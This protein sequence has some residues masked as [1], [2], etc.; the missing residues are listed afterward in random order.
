[1]IGTY[2]AVVTPHGNHFIE[3]VMYFLTEGYNIK[4]SISMA[5][6]SFID[7][8]DQKNSDGETGIYLY[9]YNTYQMYYPIIYIG[10]VFQKL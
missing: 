8:F 6:A 5:Q 10:D 3:Q 2:D 7:Y 4:D 1:M 9:A